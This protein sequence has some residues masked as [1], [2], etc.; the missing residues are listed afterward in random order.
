MNKEKLGF[1]PQ[2]S[3][4]EGTKKAVTKSPQ[5]FYQLGM[6]Y[7]LNHNLLAVDDVETLD[8]LLNTLTGE[9]VNRFTIED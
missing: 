5:P 1:A 8:G 3:K 4:G 7:L 9:V 6:N 2:R